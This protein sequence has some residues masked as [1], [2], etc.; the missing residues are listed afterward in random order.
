MSG[1]TP[2]TEVQ[3]RG[4]SVRPAQS[5]AG[6]QTTQNNST[7]LHPEYARL[8]PH[9]GEDKQDKPP[10]WSLAAPL[11]RIVRNGMRP[12]EEIRPARQE[13]PKQKAPEDEGQADGQVEKQN[14]NEEREP[15]AT[16]PPAAHPA[17][18]AEAQGQREAQQK[19]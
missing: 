14:I 4:G 6:P 9:Y 15:A 17:D 12:D 11:P 7:Y 10:V 1:Q 5:L 3:T 19:L 2:A 13:P 8:N 16:E 18:N